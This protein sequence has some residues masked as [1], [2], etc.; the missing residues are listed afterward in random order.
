MWFLLLFP[1]FLL[2][3][4]L[5]RKNQQQVF[6]S[7]G[8]PG[9]EPH[10]FF[11]NLL[12]FNPNS[13]PFIFW[14]KEGT[15]KYGKIWGY[16][17]GPKPILVIS[18]LEC[19]QDVFVKHFASF[20][21]RR[22]F[23]IQEDSDKDKNVSMFNAHGNRWK[24]LRT[25]V[26]PAF[27]EVKMRKM[28]PLM[29]RCI[30]MLMSNIDRISSKGESFDVFNHYKRLTMEVIGECAFGTALN[31]QNDDNPDNI[32]SKARIL[33]ETIRDRNFIILFAEAV[34]ELAVP[35]RK[36]L[37]LFAFLSPARRAA[38]CILSTINNVIQRR[39]EEAMRRMD[40]LQLMLDAESSQDDVS[41][42]EGQKALN[43]DEVAA[44]SLIFFIAGYETS[45]NALGIIT[46][47]LA[48]HPEVQ[49]RA[50]VSPVLWKPLLCLL[51]TVA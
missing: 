7:L 30:D 50:Q 48:T 11:G 2:L 6:K 9:P 13:H 8:I 4:Y 42:M 15:K 5:R 45:S 36:L 47:L 38:M 16:Y 22:L 32:L 19:V 43:K 40:I 20:H 29:K 35:I 37:N 17:E 49:E 28:F 33:F 44:Q 39:K 18:D 31:I 14:I 12:D 24:R 46:H 21:G 10:W 26:N 1:V 23:V 41:S 3:F 34:P 25:I 51:F 27:T